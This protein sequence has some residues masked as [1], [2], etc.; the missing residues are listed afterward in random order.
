MS[1]SDGLGHPFSQLLLFGDLMLN[2]DWDTLNDRP[3]GSILSLVLP[4]Q[5]QLSLGNLV[6]GRI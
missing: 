3:P 1:T 6:L 4:H 2:M 5:L